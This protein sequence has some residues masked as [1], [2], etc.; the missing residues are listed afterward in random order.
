MPTDLLAETEISATFDD[1]MASGS[2]GCNTYSAVYAGDD[3]SLTFESV[4]VTEM[5]CGEAAGVMEQEQRYLGTLEDVATYRIHGSQLWLET[6]DGQAL[7]Y[8]V[9]ATPTSPTAVSWRRACE[10]WTSP[11]QN[12]LQK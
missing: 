3:S 11:T 8:T 2:A 9:K 1:G 10:S 6:E 4:A 7:V 5:A 12:T